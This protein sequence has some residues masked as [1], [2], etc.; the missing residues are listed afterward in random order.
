MFL[1]KSETPVKS[2]I[3]KFFLKPL[4]SLFHDYWRCNYFRLDIFISCEQFR[5]LTNNAGE[6]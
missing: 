6:I 4:N 3:F 1:E 5:V 2:N